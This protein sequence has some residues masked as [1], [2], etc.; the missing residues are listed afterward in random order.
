MYRVAKVPPPMLSTEAKAFFHQ[1]E[2]NAF[3]TTCSVCTYQALSPPSSE[4]LSTPLCNLHGVFILQ[5]F[6]VSS[7]NLG[8][9]VGSLAGGCKSSSLHLNLSHA[10]YVDLM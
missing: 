8:A 1:D 7:S 3:T 9:F 5:G 10:M 4:K 2:G 6:V